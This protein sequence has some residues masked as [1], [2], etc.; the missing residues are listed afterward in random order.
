MASFD[1]GNITSALSDLKEYGVS[2]NGKA[3]KLESEADGNTFFE[4]TI[5]LFS[6]IFMNKLIQLR[7]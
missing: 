1:L 4:S 5:V 2:I 6:K 3:L 7:T